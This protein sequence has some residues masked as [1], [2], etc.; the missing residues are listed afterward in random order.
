[1]VQCEGRLYSIGSECA[2]WKQGAS[3]VRQ[4]IQ[5]GMLS[6]EGSSNGLGAC[7]GGQIPNKKLD[8]LVVGYGAQFL[9]DLQPL[10]FAPPSNNHRSPAPSKLLRGRLSDAV[11][12]PRYKDYLAY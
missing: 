8:R 5:F 1:M 7:N 3:V 9:H 2:P 12:R 6:L 10:I 11:R 4:H